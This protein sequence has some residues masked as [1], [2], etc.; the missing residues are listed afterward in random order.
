MGTVREHYDQVLAGFYTWLYGGYT[1]ALKSNTEFIIRHG[2]T[3]AGS[4]VAVDLGAGSGFQ[5]IP[6]ATAGFSVTAIDFCEQLLQELSEKDTSGSIR[7][8]QDDLANFDRH[9]PVGIEL[10]TC[11][12]D[13]LLHLE[14]EAKVRSLARKVFN[15]LEQNGRFVVTFRDLTHELTGLDRF[16][17]VRCD[18][19]TIF[20]CF[21][22]YRPETVYVHDIIYHDN[23]GGWQL[24]K[25][26]YPKLRLSAGWVTD[27]LTDAGLKIIESGNNN[28]LVTIIAQKPL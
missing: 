6:L 3:P 16:L 9:V 8:V 5:S 14:S 24:Y 1:A 20:T 11:M 4:A 10:I 25:S 15:S 12:T 13:T 26:C 2:I 21:L 18:E 17:P 7:T 22:E 19:K 28:G 23:G 27:C